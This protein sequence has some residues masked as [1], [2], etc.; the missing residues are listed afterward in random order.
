MEIPIIDTDVLDGDEFDL[1]DFKIRA[2]MT[3]GHTTGSVCYLIG[4]YLFTG[5]LFE[6]TH[7][8]NRLI[9][10]V[11]ANKVNMSRKK[12]IEMDGEIIIQPGHGSSFKIKNYPHL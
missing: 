12:I 9:P 8:S 4:K 10:G 7:I 1:E 5:D 11:D 3:P 6:N 2:I